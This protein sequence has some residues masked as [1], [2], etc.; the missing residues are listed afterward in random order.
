MFFEW[1]K[2]AVL[3]IFGASRYV[4]VRLAIVLAEAPDCHPVA[5]LDW[6]AVWDKSRHRGA[7]KGPG[8]GVAAHAGT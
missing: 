1:A 2:Y 3:D 8:A 7:A 5:A 4:P 6:G